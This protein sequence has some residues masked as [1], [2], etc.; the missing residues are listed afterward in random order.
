M[1]ECKCV[2][3]WHKGPEVGKIEIEFGIAC[4][5]GH[6]AGHC[7]KNRSLILFLTELLR[8]QLLETHCR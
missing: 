8:V 1:Y 5:S 4:Y 6:S 2:A 7:K 3:A